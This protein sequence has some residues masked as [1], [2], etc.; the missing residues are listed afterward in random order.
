[1][2]F[3]A[4][5]DEVRAWEELSS[6]PSFSQEL[7]ALD[8]TTTPEFIQSVLPPASSPATSPGATSA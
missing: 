3:V 7:I 2:S 4:T 5:P 6:K 1:M 8:F